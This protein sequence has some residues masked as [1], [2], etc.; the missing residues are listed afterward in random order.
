[1]T[2]KPAKRQKTLPSSS[3]PKTTSLATPSLYINEVEQYI[4]YSP[5]PIHQS[6]SQPLFFSS[7]SFCSFETENGE[8]VIHISLVSVYT[9]PYLL[10]TAIT[11]ALTS[12][13]LLAI[14]IISSPTTIPM[15]IDLIKSLCAASLSKLEESDK[16]MS[17]TIGKK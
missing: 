14:T 16:D 5:L 9:S 13:T 15:D 6:L 4:V 1:M 12:P 8:D 2:L 3:S 17:L 10:P 11:S 7:S